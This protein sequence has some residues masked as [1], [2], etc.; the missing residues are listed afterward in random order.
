MDVKNVLAAKISITRRNCLKGEPNDG[1][2]THW[3][4]QAAWMTGMCSNKF[5]YQVGC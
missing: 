5:K 2:P 3:R 4:F 1:H